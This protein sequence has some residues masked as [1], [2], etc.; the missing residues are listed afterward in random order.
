MLKMPIDTFFGPPYIIYILSTSDWHQYCL[1]DRCLRPTNIGPFISSL[2]EFV[3]EKM[4]EKLNPR[5]KHLLKIPSSA[6]TTKSASGARKKKKSVAIEDPKEKA[7]VASV[8]ALAS[9]VA[10]NG[11]QEGS[12]KNSSAGSLMRKSALR[13]SASREAQRESK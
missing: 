2:Q 9:A 3:E 6:S 13:V 11:A 7:A 10:S 12:R 1:H 5:F 8:V 4:L